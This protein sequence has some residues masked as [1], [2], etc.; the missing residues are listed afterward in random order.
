MPNVIYAFAL[1]CFALGLTEFVTVGLVSA[2]SHSVD[3]DVAAVGLAVT[4]YALGVVIGASILTALTA[5]RPRKPLLLI[6]MFTFI[7][8]NLIAGG[9]SHLLPLLVGRLLSGFAHGIYFAVASSVTTQLVS[10]K[11]AG[12]ALSTVYGGVTVAMALGAPIGTWVGSM[13]PWQIIF[14]II[15][16]FGALGLIG[17]W[18]FMPSGTGDI[19]HTNTK[20][21]SHVAVLL[22]RHLVA[23][24]C[25]PILAYTG[26]FTLYTYIS[27]LLLT[28]THVSAQTA[29]LLVLAYGVGAWVGNLI[30]GRLTDRFGMDRASMLLLTG[31]LTAM[32]LMV[33]FKSMLLPMTVLIFI[34][35]LTTIGVLVPLQTRILNLARRHAPHA[36]DVASG[37]NIAAFNSGIM[38]GSLLGSATI[39]V[40][41][42][43]CTALVGTPVVA[44]S[45]LLLVW[46]MRVSSMQFKP[47]N[48]AD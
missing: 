37:M 14:V 44:A 38:L 26:S 21:R 43:S 45:I 18:M 30:S 36:L 12:A 7:L 8:G 6:T 17:L 20:A 42:L 15:A 41:G 35:G 16:G 3:A 29:S 24:A 46:Q 27:P 2:I 10:Q 9:S 19:D 39:S 47:L 48:H 5:S 34:L 11:R 32:A 25:V 28:V 1:C 23:G 22:N 13:F 4:A 31:M 40:L 33:I